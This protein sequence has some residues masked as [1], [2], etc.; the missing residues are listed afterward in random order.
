M[1]VFKIEKVQKIRLSAL[2][3]RSGCYY[4]QIITKYTFVFSKRYVFVIPSSL[5]TDHQRKPTI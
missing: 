1:S 4:Y 3:T 5:V 2:P